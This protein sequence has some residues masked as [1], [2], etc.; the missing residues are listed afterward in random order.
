MATETKPVTTK[1]EDK[2]LALHKAL[3]KEIKS[4]ESEEIQADYEL[5]NAVLAT[6]RAISNALVDVIEK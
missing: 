5:K 3:A 1:P 2:F 6:L 4:I